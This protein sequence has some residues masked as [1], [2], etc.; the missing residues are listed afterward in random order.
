MGMRTGVVATSR[1]VQATP[2]AFAVSNVN[3]RAEHEI[4]AQFLNAPLDLILAGGTNQFLPEEE[5]CEREDGRDITAEMQER[6]FSYFDDIGRI[7][8]TETEDKVLGLFVPQNFEPYPDRGEI[9]TDLTRAAIA[10]LSRSD[11]GF[12]LMVEGSQIDWAG[13]DNLADWMAK[14]VLDLD[15][16]VGAALDFAERDANTLALV[17]ADHETGDR[18]STRLN[19]SHVAISYAVF[20]L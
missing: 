6:G 16:A 10:N 1:V 3:R 5:G 9:T 4:A 2:A 19:S 11:N 13:H 15:N 12:F 17:T 18:K 20:C 14:E 7:S 8:E